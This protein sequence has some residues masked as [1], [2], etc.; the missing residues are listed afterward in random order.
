MKEKIICYIKPTVVQNPSIN[1]SFKECSYDERNDR[2]LVESFVKTINFDK[3]TKRLGHKS[4]RKSADSLS[5]TDRKVFLIEFK[6]GNQLNH[7]NKISRLISGVKKK[8]NDSEQTLYED[9]FEKCLEKS[10]YPTIAFY[11]VVDSKEIG[12]DIYAREL[13]NLSLGDNMSVY[14]KTLFEQVLPN[15]KLNCVN[16]TRFCDIDVWYSELFDTYLSSYG[17]VPMEVG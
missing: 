16:P 10:D 1:V 12:A 11:L 3:L 15:L 7:E 4:D 17:V 8:I 2:Y 5:L 9:I 13:A 14:E 6:T